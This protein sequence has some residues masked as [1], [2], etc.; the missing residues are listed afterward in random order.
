MCRF[1]SIED[2]LDIDYFQSCLCENCP[3]H[4]CESIGGEHCLRRAA[5]ADITQEFKR[6]NESINSILDRNKNI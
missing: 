4:D 1:F 2:L 3:R 5:I 6:F